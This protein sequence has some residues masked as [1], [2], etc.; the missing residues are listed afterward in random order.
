MVVLALCIEQGVE[1]PRRGREKSQALSTVL[2]HCDDVPIE[3]I[4]FA[5]PPEDIFTTSRKLFTFIQDA[6]FEIMKEEIRSGL[7]KKPTCK[8]FPKWYL[9]KVNII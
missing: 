3:S 6:F 4:C 8:V 1:L 7:Q 2:H 5:G 9:Q